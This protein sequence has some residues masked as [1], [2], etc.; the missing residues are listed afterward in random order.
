MNDEEDESIFAYVM[1]SCQGCKEE[2]IS[3]ILF[4][5]RDTLCKDCIKKFKQLRKIS[6]KK[7]PS[8]KKI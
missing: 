3:D 8:L 2:D 5:S 6:R 1:D 7:W 4:L